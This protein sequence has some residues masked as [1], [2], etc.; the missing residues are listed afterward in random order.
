MQVSFRTVK[1]AESGKFQIFG[2]KYT[3]SA[4]QCASWFSFYSVWIAPYNSIPSLLKYVHFRIL[5]WHIFSDYKQ[6][7][8]YGNLPEDFFETY[9]KI[10]FHFNVLKRVNLMIN[11]FIFQEHHL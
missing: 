9:P 4:I 11:L 6:I 2:N 7:D 10:N 8:L 5:G 1:D 3:N